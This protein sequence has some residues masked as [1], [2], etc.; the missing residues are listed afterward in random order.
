MVREV[1]TVNVGECGINVGHTTWQQYCSEHKIDCDGKLQKN[2]EYYRLRS[3]FEEK[4]KGVFT[5]RNCMISLE[6]EPIDRIANN[7]SLY[8]KLYYPFSFINHK[9]GSDHLF[10]RAHY[11]TGT[12]IRNKVMD[13]FVHRSIYKHY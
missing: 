10:A 3:F 5:C 7:Q 11:V 9:E 13:Y 4:S 2:V 1:L 12:E 8:S 6:P